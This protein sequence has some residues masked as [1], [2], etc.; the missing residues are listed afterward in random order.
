MLSH[1]MKVFKIISTRHLKMSISQNTIVTDK[2]TVGMI[3][4][5]IRQMILKKLNMP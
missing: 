5:V 3:N 1:S 4:K 2:G